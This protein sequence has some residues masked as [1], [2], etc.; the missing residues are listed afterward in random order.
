MQMLE[1]L[2]YGARFGLLK[3]CDVVSFAWHVQHPEWSTRKSVHHRF[4]VPI[5]GC[6]LVPSEEDFKDLDAAKHRYAG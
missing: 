4:T 5:H 6:S 1:S 2:S 3:V